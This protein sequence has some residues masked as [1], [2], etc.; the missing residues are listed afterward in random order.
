M[1]MGVVVGAHG[2]RGVLRIRSF[3]AVPEAIASYGPLE[4]ETGA[5]RFA[6]RIE[7]QARGAV[8]A[9]VDGIGDRDGAAALRGTKLYLPRAALPPTGAEEF[10]H[11]DLVGLRA[12]LIDGRALGKVVAVHDYGA[13]TS[14]EIERREGGTVLVPFT[15]RAVPVV[16]LRDGSLAIDP[17]AGL[18]DNRPIE[19]EQDEKG[20][21]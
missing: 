12:E 10:Y 7:G 20:G 18:L 15:K 21:E 14:L 6:L 17:P 11:A 19:A 2:V 5:R 1:L 9:A 8:L 3:A 13:G 16:D 4:D